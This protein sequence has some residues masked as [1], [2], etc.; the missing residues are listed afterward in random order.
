MKENMLLNALNFSRHVRNNYLDC[1]LH[2]YSSLNW[3]DYTQ[4]KAQCG[5]TKL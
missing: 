2:D 3:N 4:A 5:K 1:P